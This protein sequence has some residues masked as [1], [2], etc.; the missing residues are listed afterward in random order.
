MALLHPLICSS[1]EK[2][3]LPVHFHC[4]SGCAEVGTV[5]TAIDDTIAVRKKII[6]Q[7]AARGA[8]CFA[9]ELKVLMSHMA[10]S[11]PVTG[12]SICGADE[13]ANNS[14]LLAYLTI[15]D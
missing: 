12:R 7:V 14:W 13:A 2:S 3:G 4:L 6:M 15:G 1:G 5:V 10:L 11:F 9:E 8:R